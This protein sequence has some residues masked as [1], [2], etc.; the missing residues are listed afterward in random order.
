MQNL[1]EIITHKFFFFLQHFGAVIL[2]YTE[3][4]NYYEVSNPIS[5]T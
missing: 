1:N 2:K 5:I 4:L 3:K